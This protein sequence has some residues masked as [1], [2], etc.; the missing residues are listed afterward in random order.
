MMFENRPLRRPCDL[1]ALGARLSRGLPRA[2]A[3]GAMPQPRRGG[4]GGYPPEGCMREEEAAATAAPRGEGEWKEGGRDGG[5]GL[6]D[7]RRPPARPCSRTRRRANNQRISARCVRFGAHAGRPS[8]GALPL[9]SA[10]LVRSPV[11]NRHSLRMNKEWGRV[12]G[13]M[14]TPCPARHGPNPI[15][16]APSP[17]TF[18]LR[19]EPSRK[20]SWPRPVPCHQA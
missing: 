8:G 15:E 6:D 18:S 2:G 14:L 1:G 5:F 4:R 10:R 9:P 17:T 12:G 3:E 11:L 20:V 7:A 13:A 16:Y 19:A